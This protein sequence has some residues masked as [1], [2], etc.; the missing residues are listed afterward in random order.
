MGLLFM[1]CC[2]VL[3][4][5]RQGSCCLHVSLFRRLSPVLA[6]FCVVKSV[7]P[8]HRMRV[9]GAGRLSARVRARREGF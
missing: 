5:A 6:G 8:D 7:L 4:Y 9:A 3:A 1:A 2:V